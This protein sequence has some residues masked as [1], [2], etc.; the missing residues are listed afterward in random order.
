MKGRLDEVMDL[1]REVL[2]SGGEFQIAPEGTSML[3]LI[4]PGRDTVILVRP[5]HPLSA[6]AIKPAGGRAAPI[7]AEI[8]MHYRRVLVH[9][10][11]AASPL[12]SPRVRHGSS[13]PYAPDCHRSE[14]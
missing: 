4:R 13:R 8:K 9:G 12:R 10:G 14:R 1:L 11:V 6:G 7:L 5:H 2:A 3:P